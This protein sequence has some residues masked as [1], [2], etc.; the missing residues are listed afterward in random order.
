MILNTEPCK[1]RYV[2]KRYVVCLAIIAIK[3]LIIGFLMVA[4][5]FVL[6]Y[7]TISF[8]ICLITSIV[9]VEVKYSSITLSFELT[10]RMMEG[11]NSPIYAFF[12]PVPDIEQ[13]EDGRWYHRFHCFAK[14]CKGSVKRYLDTK[15][16]G[17]TSNM[18]KHAKICWG[19]ETVQAAMDASNLDGARSVLANHKDGSIAAAFQ[20]KGKGKVTYSQRQH[21]RQQT[22]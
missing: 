6:V 18:R 1:E 3:A 5:L 16:S 13:D 9:L 19:A 11:W 14:S 17:S 15:D 20:V 8:H 7:I 22:R 2:G 10:E 21:T 12:R 4:Q